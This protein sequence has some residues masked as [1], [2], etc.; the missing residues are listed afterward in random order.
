MPASHTIRRVLAAAALIAAVAVVAVLALGSR[1]GSYTVHARFQNASQLVKGNLV[2]VAGASVGKIE[3]ID[4]T[5]DGQADVRM[6]ITDDGYRPLRRGTKA[7]IREA[8]L[9]GVANRYVDLQLPPGRPPAD[10]P[11]R[12]RHRPDRHDDRRRPRPALRHLR[13]QD[14][15]GAQR[16]HPR[17]RQLLRGPGRA[18]QRRLGVPEPVAGRLEPAVRGARPRHARPA[19]LRRRVLAAGRRPRRA[20]R[21]PRRPR[22]PPRDHDRRDRRARSRRC[23]RAIGDLPGFMRRA[24]HDVRQP[25]RDARRPRAARR[26]VKARGQE[27]APVPRRAAPA[28]PRRAPDAARPLR[29][30]CARRAPPT[31]S[32]S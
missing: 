15:Q 5:P 12:R 32:S 3:A 28:G 30:W 26:R 31:T 20:P 22:R 16:G 18:G 14:A 21:G 23:R 6:K 11:R 29:A 1:G 8:S 24:E 4:L 7:I 10:D 27:A 17:L 19:A 9:S 13:P 2:Q 25:A